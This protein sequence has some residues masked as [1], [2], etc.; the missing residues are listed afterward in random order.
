MPRNMAD[1]DRASRLPGEMGASTARLETA[2]TPVAAKAPA[3]V[4]QPAR[5][6]E[7]RPQRAGR[8]GRR[9]ARK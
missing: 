2:A 6:S 8:A 4:R 9:T 3:A 7:T 5:A 1:V